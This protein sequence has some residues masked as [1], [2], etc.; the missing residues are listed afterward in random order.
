M[1]IKNFTSD[2]K[3]TEFLYKENEYYSVLFYFITSQKEILHATNKEQK[4]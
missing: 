1:M 4:M 2:S 3:L